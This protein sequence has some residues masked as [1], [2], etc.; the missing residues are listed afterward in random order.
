MSLIFYPEYYERFVC[1]ADKC[2]DT[3][4]A[5][6][7][8]CIDDETLSFYKGVSGVFGERLR[9][10]IASDDDGEAVF[11]QKNGRCPFLNDENLCDIH[12][13]LGEA[14]TCEVCREH[15]RFTEIYDGFTEKS[16]SVSCPAANELIFSAPLT[17][18]TYPSPDYS[19]S[20]ELLAG[21]I[22]SRKLLLDHIAGG[23]TFLRSVAFLREQCKNLA[24]T[25][26]EY[27]DA[28]D[29]YYC[30]SGKTLRQFE[31]FL[32]ERSEILTA[33][34][35]V[36]LKAAVKT[37]LSEQAFRCFRDSEEDNVKKCFSYFVYRYFL[38]AVND[39]EIELNGAFIAL[40]IYT[41]IDISA[42]TGTAFTECIRL[43]SKEIEHDLLN[44]EI[45]K[46]HISGEG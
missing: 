13:A 21:L 44:I 11:R 22:S 25:M 35:R 4:C 29:G 36:L 5:G 9:A 43:F 32:L 7:E 26:F 17:V 37:E 34:W 31:K 3:C 10:S 27:N 16:L 28:Y 42:K 12:I 40:S 41:C 14:H 30:F 45:M 18:N 24:D 19:G 6:W 33:E 20:D 15:P 1:S 8:I 38:K 46:D 2:P 39:E 23:N